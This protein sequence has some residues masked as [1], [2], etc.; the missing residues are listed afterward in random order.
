M[1]IQ[2]LK[3][4]TFYH[5][6]SNLTALIEEPTSSECLSFVEE[7]IHRQYDMIYTLKMMC[8]L[9]QVNSGLDRR[10]FL[11]LKEQFL[12]SYGFHHIVTFFNLKKVFCYIKF[13]YFVFFVLVLKTSKLKILLFFKVLKFISKIYACKFKLIKF[14]AIYNFIKN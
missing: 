8:L 4:F 1:L 9:C 10:T 3:Y 13:V 12:R 2:F 7:C 11:N 5:F 6:F 14:S